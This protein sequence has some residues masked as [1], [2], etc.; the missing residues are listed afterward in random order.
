MRKSLAYLIL[1]ALFIGQPVYAVQP[2]IEAGDITSSGNDT[3]ATAN[4]V[5]YPAYVSGDLLIMFWGGDD[6]PTA[7]TITAP[8]SGGNSETLL[9]SNT[10]SGGNSGDGPTQGVIA[11]VGDATVS[12]GSLTWTRGNAEEW[13]GRTVKVLAGEFDAST[14]LGTLSGYSGQSSDA[15]TIATPVFNAGASD[16]GGTIV[17]GIITDQDPITGTPG[18]W[19]APLAMT[20]HGAVASAIAVR[21]AA[22]VDSTE[23]TSVNYTMTLDSAST[24]AVI[25]RAPVGGAGVYDTAPTVTSQTATAYT[26]GG[27][28]DASGDVDAAACPKDQAAPSIAQV[29][30]GNCTGDVAADGTGSAAPATTPWDFSFTVT[31]SSTFPIYDVYVT[32]GT[33]LTTLADEFLD[34]PTNYEFMVL[35]SVGVQA[36]N[37]CKVINDTEDPDIATGDILTAVSATSPDTFTI[38]WVNDCNFSYDGTEDRQFIEIQ[39]VYDLS[40]EGFHAFG[41][42]TFA[43][44]NNSPVCGV[45]LATTIW[46]EDAAI[47]AIDMSADCPDAESDT[48]TCVL[49]S[50]TLPNGITAGG[51]GN[52]TLS[53]TPDTEDEIGVELIY[54]VSDPYSGSD[55]LIFTTYVVNTW[56]MPDITGD[57]VAAAL[58]TILTAAPWYSGVSINVTGVC[59][60][61]VA[62]DD[63]I[64]Q[65]PTASSEVDDP[66]S[67][68]SAVISTGPI[69]SCDNQNTTLGGVS[70]G[71]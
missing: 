53:G 45:T 55:E 71:M 15:T 20:D 3:A 67:V 21:T 47:D 64:E 37:P 48:L 23:I 40:A 9:I 66:L 43:V 10:G 41:I 29:L 14:P 68:I 26:V 17:V 13:A 16:G 8:A 59:S 49:D 27:S 39:S 28:L 30:A 12:S 60:D 65:T 25:V 46:D 54:T 31:P 5:D 36:T 51:T 11:W 44:N 70:I 52:C 4:T 24:I 38:T 1:A 32:D 69:S 42:V 19:S 18:G 6:D 63:I 33:T 50:G 22:A 2:V 34:P 61:A 56:T 35:T 7:D 62:A 57:T 58:T